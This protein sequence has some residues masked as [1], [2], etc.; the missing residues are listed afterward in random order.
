MAEPYSP[1]EAR[2]FP[3]SAGSA[4]RLSAKEGKGSPTSY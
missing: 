2:L 4:A 3:N 1:S